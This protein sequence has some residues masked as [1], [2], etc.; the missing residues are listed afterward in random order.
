MAIGALRVSVA[1]LL[2]A[3]LAAGCGGGPAQ[4]AG[5]T[6]DAATAPASSPAAAPSTSPAGAFIDPSVPYG[7]FGLGDRDCA[8]VLEAAAAALG[9]ADA[10]VSYV[11]VGPFG[12]PAGQGCESS[13]LARPA[14]GVVLELVDAPPVELSVELLGDGSLNVE[15]AEGFMVSVEP[16]SAP[17][18]LLGPTSFSLGHC[19]LGS[20]IDIDGSWWDP[21]GL[22][23]SDHGD[24][25]N[26]AEGTIA[27]VG[28][29]QATFTSKGGFSVALVR[30]RGVKHLPLCQ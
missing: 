19:G 11:Q 29:N 14:G 7:C 12:C 4:S 23:N 30:H 26:A 8:T 24:A 20:G 1:V 22:V 16:S 27:P 5:P 13:L 21:V 15:R 28:P 9:P 6:A 25:I 3:T 18:G 17:G 10:P 2:L